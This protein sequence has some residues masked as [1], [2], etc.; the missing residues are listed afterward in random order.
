MTDQEQ[1]GRA[2]TAAEVVWAYLAKQ[3][4]VIDQYADDV[5][6]DGPDAVHKSR[7]AAR[8]SR[9][10]LKIYRSVLDKRSARQL[11]SGLKW[12]GEKLGAP[13]DAEV[14]RDYL[15]DLVGELDGDS[16]VGPVAER[17]PAD[18]EAEHARAHA[19]LVEALDTD[20]Y[21]EVRGLF[22][23]LVATRPSSELG[24]RPATEVLPGLLDASVERARAVRAKAGGD[25]QVLE[26][27]HDVRKAAKAVRY[28]AEALVDTFGDAAAQIA[29][30]WEAVTESLGSMQDSVVGEH[31]L[32]QRAWAAELAG[33]PTDTYLTL[34]GLEL[35]RRK[36]ALERGIE[37]VDSA[38]AAGVDL[39]PA[40]DAAN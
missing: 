16:L 6:A 22:D 18:L 24:E 28:C 11:E 15:I 30:R 1:P 25:L 23:E 38:L 39:S 26:P 2:D 32:A 8:R 35:A 19:A 9:S 12:F 3:A 27:W 31:V 34:I 7:V 17:L 20:R 4:E 14:L 21:R 29:K 36:D 40:G 5:R 37:A 13:R 33:E 10:I